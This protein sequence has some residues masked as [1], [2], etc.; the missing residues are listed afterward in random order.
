METADALLVPWSGRAIMLLDLDAFFASVEQLDHPEW[1]GKP[2]IVGGDADRHG[3]VA[4]C[5]YEARTYGVRSAMPAFTARKLCPDAIWVAGRHDRY[6]ELSRQ[7]M[8]LIG[9]ETPYVEQVSIDE[10]FADITP[11]RVNTEHPAV[12][13]RRIQ[14]RVREE[15][16][17][18]CSIGLGSTKSVAKVA[19]DMDKPHGLTVVL[20]G[21]EAQ[22]MGPLPIKV[23]SGVGKAA[24][25]RL[26]AAGVRTL[27]D[28]ACA[29]ERL[30][31]SVFGSRAEMMRARAMG[32]DGSAI[33]TEREVKSVSHETTF[34]DVLDAR[35]DIM[36]ALSTLLGK[37]ARR[38][39]KKGLRA[40]TLAVKV[41][42]EDRSVRSAQMTVT[43]SSDDELAL[44]AHLGPLLDK[45]WRPHE[46]VRL[47]GVRA[48]GLEQEPERNVQEAL[49]DLPEDG[50]SEAA[51]PLID[52]P[53]KRRGLITATDALKDRFGE[54]AV[55]FGAA[56][57]NK[58]NTTGSVT[59]HP[60]DG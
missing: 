7:V 31:A 17:I 38:L 59:Q 45:V 20:P 33:A 42:M 34:A 1:R 56:L 21:S 2:V 24:H 10:A 44:A 43:P 47:L 49:F 48:S 14:R 8:G 13:A 29:D 27:A 15:V 52:D 53:D 9:D 35:D 11:S 32:A 46:R 6:R 18:T 30:M 5:S 4:T 55:F 50:A 40:H 22:F 51:A 54:E 57:R 26:T 39:R 19:S 28:L 25:Q 60:A 58:G 37:V 3:V 23:L 41:R 36:A 12:V 16:G